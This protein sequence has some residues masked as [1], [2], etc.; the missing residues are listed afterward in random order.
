MDNL[1]TD[2][3]ALVALVRQRPEILGQLFQTRP[4]LALQVTHSLS[5]AGPRFDTGGGAIVEKSVETHGGH[6]IGRDFVQVVIRSL[7]KGED[8]EDARNNVALYLAALVSDLAGLKLGN[9]SGA[10]DKTRQTPL[11]LADIYVPLDTTTR[12]KT[13]TPDKPKLNA[14]AS[15]ERSVSVLEALARHRTLTL[16]G[17]PGSG[18]STFG[19]HVLLALAQTW[20]DHA[21]QLQTLGADW[22]HGPLLPIRVVLRRFAEQL[23]PGDAPAQA[24]D[25]WNFIGADLMAGSYGLSDDAVRHLRAV[26]SRHG[27]LFLLDGLDECG[28]P[29]RR[30]RVQ[31]AVNALMRSAG[32]RCRFLLTARPYAW[33]TGADPDEGVYELADLRREQIETFIRGWYAALVRHQW[34]PQGEAERLVEDL[35]RARQ[36]ADLRPLAA[37]PLLLTLMATLHTNRGGRLPDDRA[38][39][40]NES[41]E[42]L[43]LRW[44]QHIGADRALL[45]ELGLRHLKLSDVRETLEALAFQIHEENT[46]Q[47]GTADIGEDRLIRALRPL[48]DDS[49][50]KAAIVVDYIEK[51]AGLLIGQGPRADRHGERQF[52]F[53]HRTF[54]EFMAACHLAA[55][56]SFPAECTRLACADADHWKVVLP[57]AARVAK[58]ERGASAADELIGSCD[59]DEFTSANHPPQTRNWRCALLAG[60]QLQEIGVNALRKSPRTERILQRVIVWL[61]AAMAAHHHPD[62]AGL[63]AK[64]RVRAGD[65]L[66]FLGDPRFDP[67]RFHLPR[68]NDLGFA[69]LPGYDDL[70][71]ARYPV[72][73]AQFRAFVV[74]SGFEPGDPDCLRDPDH[75]PVRYVNHA[76]ALAYCEWLTGTGCLPD[77]WRADLPDEHEW[78]HASRGGASDKWDYWWEGEADL[79]R[80]NCRDT[81]IGDTSVVGCFPVNGYGLYD[82]LGNVWEW[83]KS[84]RSESV[85][86]PVVRG[87]SWFNSADGLRCAYRSWNLPVNRSGR[88]GFRVVLRRSPV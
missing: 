40:Y 48:L 72:T 9:I 88:L 66:S 68:G 24:G 23:P 42:L 28:N 13:E 63:V 41:V 35:L 83:T 80:A 50:D 57:L 53:P 31:A 75:R 15:D 49:R 18:K 70:R 71:F 67:D 8:A 55:S 27:A 2:L 51:R 30:V 33:L 7:P 73:V 82:I 47:A 4:D 38:D 61:E 11:Q 12:V 54:Q 43:L 26:A 16:L 62:S 45:D 10:R 81:G 46:G 20:R 52:S 37:N 58:A 17:K 25:L 22:T 86:D 85:S 56:D 39:L 1:P 36:R 64:E 74:D 69:L 60:L 65:T 6:F 29:V 34:L 21:D 5:N 19:A 87:G 3:P 32:P 78:E 77:G 59:V 84:P 79:E 76:E 14:L 44:N